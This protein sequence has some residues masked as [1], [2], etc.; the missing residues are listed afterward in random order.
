MNLEQYYTFTNL[1]STAEYLTPLRAYDICRA[2]MEGMYIC[3]LYTVFQYKECHQ[4]HGSVSLS[5]LDRFSKHLSWQK[6]NNISYNIGY[7]KYFLP[8]AKYVA[9]LLSGIYRKPGRKHKRDVSRVTLTTTTAHLSFRAP[10]FQRN[11]YCIAI[12]S[13]PCSAFFT[14]VLL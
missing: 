8:L 7:S 9:A 10:D 1:Y 13:R 12:V 4:T 14:K 2:D 3:I 5:N 11:F 6:E